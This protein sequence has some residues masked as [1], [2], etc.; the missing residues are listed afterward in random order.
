MNTTKN[1]SRP[2]GPHIT[3]G[4]PRPGGRLARFI[5]TQDPKNAPIHEGDLVYV[6][7]E[8]QHP[9]KAVLHAQDYRRLTQ[10]HDGPKLT[11]SRWFLDEDGYL[12]AFSRLEKPYK[13]GLLV[14]AAILN[15][16]AGDTLDLPADSLDC[17]LSSM[18]KVEASRA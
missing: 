15:A 16:K 17:R 9:R 14:A 6:S 10:S 7:V 11:G 5:A 12:R 1:R 18:K 8:G 3:N 2:H 4:K 13:H